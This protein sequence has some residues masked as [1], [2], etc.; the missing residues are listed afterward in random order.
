MIRREETTNHRQRGPEKSWIFLSNIDIGE[1][2]FT[3]RQLNFIKNP[4]GKRE[5]CSAC[6]N[7]IISTS[8]SESSSIPVVTSG[9]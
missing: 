9:L 5:E 6:L 7:H 1:L 2:Y 8:P 4:I 3:A